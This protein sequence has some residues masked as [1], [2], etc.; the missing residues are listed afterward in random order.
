MESSQQTVHPLS[1]DEC[2]DLLQN[3]AFVGRVGFVRDQ[4]VTILPVNYLS[5]SQSIVVCTSD[6]TVLNAL[7]DGT[8]VAFEIDDSHPL[9]HSGWSVLVNGTV[10]HITDSKERDALQRGPLRSW[11]HSA[12]EQWLRISIDSIS[13]RRLNDR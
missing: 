8:A 12:S 2:I 1:H 11:A 6:G 7:P 10:C 9:E 3:S 5:D 13:G 4:Q